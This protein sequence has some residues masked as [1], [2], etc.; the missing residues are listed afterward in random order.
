MT[1]ARKPW[2]PE[3]RARHAA[4]V[5]RYQQTRKRLKFVE[6]L[7]PHDFFDRLLQI[8][9]NPKHPKHKQLMFILGSYQRQDG[10]N[11]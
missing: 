1:K 8:R 3:A 11:S 6:S 10:R 9:R 2:S 4:G 7:T 5:Q